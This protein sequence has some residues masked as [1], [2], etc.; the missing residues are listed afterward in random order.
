VPCT[1]EG[2]RRTRSSPVYV[3]QTL[4]TISVL[5]TTLLSV[6]DGQNYTNCCI[7]QAMLSE[8]TI[9]PTLDQRTTFPS[10][11]NDLSSSQSTSKLSGAAKMKQILGWS[12]CTQGLRSTTDDTIAS[13]MSSTPTT[14]NLAGK[15][16][17]KTCRRL[18]LQIDALSTF[19]S[20]LRAQGL[21]LISMNGRL[22]KRVLRLNCSY[23]L[24]FRRS[25]S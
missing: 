5:L 4:I 15:R 16:R 13:I 18:S 11:P 6:A 22:I 20:L 21:Y 25:G 8:T 9:S 23:H 19:G 1:R 10:C 17:V 24:S 2:N 7:V 14:L 12:R 3:S